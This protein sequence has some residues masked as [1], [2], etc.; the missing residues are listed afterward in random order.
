MTSDALPGRLPL[1]ALTKAAR[2]TSLE[3][4]AGAE[5]VPAAVPLVAWAASNKPPAARA[6]AP[7][8][9]GLVGRVGRNRL[10]S[11][12]EARDGHRPL[13]P[14]PPAARLVQQDAPDVGIRGVRLPDPGPVLVGLDE[15]VLHEIVGEVP[16]TAHERSA[17]MQQRA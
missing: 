11:L 2:D 13:T 9:G 5:A 16:V 1:L 17:L 15:R 10:G 8:A 6:R 14:T 3:F 4:T 12:G 7:R